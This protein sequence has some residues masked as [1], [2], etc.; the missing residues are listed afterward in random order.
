MRGFRPI[1]T[2]YRDIGGLFEELAARAEFAETTLVALNKN[3]PNKTE[4][5]PRIDRPPGENDELAEA[6]ARRIL[7]RKGFV[8]PER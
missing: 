5:K 6:R 4:P 3:A 2:I 7:R 8:E 1:A